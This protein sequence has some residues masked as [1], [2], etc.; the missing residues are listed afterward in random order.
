MV[1]KTK[2]ELEEINFTKR[3]KEELSKINSVSG[4]KSI[5]AKKRWFRS[6]NP[7]I[8][9]LMEFYKSGNQ[10][11]VME[12]YVADNERFMEL[13]KTAETNEEKRKILRDYQMFQL[14]IFELMFGNK[15]DIKADVNTQVR[16][17]T[18]T[19]EVQAKKEFL[20]RSKLLDIISEKLEKSFGYEK[21]IEIQRI[22]YESI[23]EVEAEPVYKIEETKA[24]MI[25]K[26]RKFLPQVNHDWQ[27]ASSLA[28]E[29]M[30]KEKE[31]D[32]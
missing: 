28:K 9:A 12:K 23:K 32:V 21:M 24:V 20:L 22:I 27:K 29:E 30:G 26:I 17:I 2:E 13:Y 10:L 18:E 8:N 25:T 31:I 6:N 3:S 11:E 14:K 15:L 16:N 4:N 5:G 1:Y 19:A 7:D